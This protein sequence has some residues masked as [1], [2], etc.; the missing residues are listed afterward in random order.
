M[1]TYKNVNF[2][3]DYECINVLFIESNIIPEGVM[4]EECDNE[5]LLKSNCMHLSTIEGPGII[6]KSYGY[7]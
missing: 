6:K 1:K 2:K 4:W 7:M 3:R 5:E